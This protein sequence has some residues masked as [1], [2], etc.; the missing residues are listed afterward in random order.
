MIV[1]RKSLMDNSA[2]A[3][4][5]PL[6]SRR[7]FSLVELLVTVL[8]V[9]VSLISVGSGFAKLSALEIENREKAR[10]LEA[11]C[12]RVAVMQPR[13]AVGTEILPTSAADV[14]VLTQ[15]A[16]RYPK[17]ILGVSFE[18]NSYL[19]VT[20]YA[21]RVRNGTLEGQVYSASTENNRRDTVAY[22]WQDEL[23]VK[24]R[25]RQAQM[26]G[27]YVEPMLANVDLENTGI[28]SV[29]TNGLL[30]SFCSDVPTQKGV[31]SVT[32]KVPVRL[33]N[34]HPDY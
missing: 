18:T 5:N 4:R 30:M 31:F 27:N 21:I 12:M 13:V 29:Q 14:D 16:I 26:L 32:L 6:L 23:F 3:Y 34:C 15:V 19:Q 33:M 28:L 7:G 11:L 1:R 24:Q 9:A 2:V 20:N 10:V 22:D 8:V 25:V 17:P